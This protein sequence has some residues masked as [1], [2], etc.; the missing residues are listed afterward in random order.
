[1]MNLDELN[2]QYGTDGQLVFK[3]G[4]GGLPVIEVNNPLCTAIISLQGAQV[5]SWTPL[6]C[7]QQTDSLSGA[8]ADEEATVAS[9]VIW[10]SREAGFASGQSIRGGIPICWPWFGAHRSN[11]TLPA[12]GFARV[13]LWQVLSTEILPDN[14]IRI[15][16]SLNKTNENSHMWPA[17]TSVQCQI[18]LGSKLE[19]E[20]ITHNHGNAAVTIGQ[21]LHTYFRVADIS[22]VKLHGLDEAEYLD[23]LAGYQRKRQQGPVIIDREVDRIYLDTTSDCV[24]E[25]SALKRNIV[26]IKCGSHSTVVWNP[27][28]ETAAKMGDLGKDGYKQMLCVESANAAEDEVTIEAGKDHHLWV[29]Y[30]VKTG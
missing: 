10:L 23:K 19:I 21:A 30:S 11:K 9:D 17:D 12:H 2:H 5:L 14:S 16:F 29:Q 18:T 28:Q 15:S 13:S 8:K 22:Q 4:K 20:L 26:I 25:D 27:W 3:S 6:P 1:M 7:D 24:I